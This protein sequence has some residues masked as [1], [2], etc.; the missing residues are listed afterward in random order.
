MCGYWLVHPQSS[1]REEINTIMKELLQLMLV[2]K[3]Q[4]SGSEGLEDQEASANLNSDLKLTPLLKDRLNSSFACVSYY[5]QN[6]LRN[7][8]ILQFL[9][10]I[11]KWDVVY[12]KYMSVNMT[13]GL[14]Q[15][16]Y[17]ILGYCC[18]KN[19]QNKQYL[20]KHLKDTFIQHFDREVDL[21]ATAF[22]NQLFYEND[23]VLENEEQLK[24]IIDKVFRKV[25]KLQ[26]TPTEY[27][28]PFLLHM[29]GNMMY[30]KKKNVKPYQNSILSNFF[31]LKNQ[32]YID[33][34]PAILKEY[35][36]QIL[37]AT[38]QQLFG[39]A[40]GILVPDLVCQFLSYFDLLTVC[41]AGKNSF[42][43]N[44][45][46]N[47]VSIDTIQV[48]LATPNV[49]PI[50][51]SSLLHF[52]FEVYLE[53]ERDNFFFYQQI[54][55]RVLILMVNDVSS[56]LDTPLDEVLKNTYLLSHDHC[57]TQAYYHDLCIM[58]NIEC[59]INILRKNIQ[60][61]TNSDTF[62]NFSIFVQTCLQ[63][64]KK[65]KKYQNNKI[66]SLLI[67]LNHHILQSSSYDLIVS[68]RK[69]TTGR[70]D[71]L[72]EQV[73]IFE[74]A[75]TSTD[76]LFASVLTSE[77]T[78][79]VKRLLDGLVVVDKREEDSIMTLV[80]NYSDQY[81]KSPL[82]KQR[83]YSEFKRFIDF[84][85]DLDGFNNKPLNIQSTSFITFCKTM[86]DFLS[87]ST[88]KDEV[89]VQKD[90]KQGLV[91]FRL[92]IEKGNAE[93]VKGISAWDVEDW[94]EVQEE[95]QTRQNNLL[96]IDLVDL[97]I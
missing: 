28:N 58:R 85:T 38:P 76:K 89:S 11:L 31:E 54:V 94:D 60:L 91:I 53:T 14:L 43:E 33:I 66:R 87:P 68:I 2:S 62:K 32:T 49:H 24:K 69:Q 4:K 1:E 8:N 79:K 70:G 12:H 88:D 95:I 78:N 75:Q 67:H 40:R 44:I 23:S 73:S 22:L 13:K 5:H 34:Q 7:T 6:L 46:Q 63:F 56:M 37:N 52:F 17:Q 90:Y 84:I 27:A 83:T 65:H 93:S 30:S 29:L 9:V 71:G 42:S 72:V 19:E 51:K 41:S 80:K 50:I 35:N 82:F 26:K 36:D 20:I 92:Y 16:I 97:L 61:A 45:S 3:N 48:V 39:S 64:I 96:E 59:F 57:Q 55:D 47:L 25:S 77:S 15:S 86:I 74:D 18:W 10:K 81:F 21:G